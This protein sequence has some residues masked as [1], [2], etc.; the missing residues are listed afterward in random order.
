MEIMIAVSAPNKPEREV[1]LSSDVVVGRG[2]TANLRIISN[3]VSREHC[4]LIVADDKIAIRDLGSS[5]GT[6]LDGTTIEAK[7]DVLLASGSRLEIG[8]L[9]LVVRF[10]EAAL[11][12]EFRDALH[13]QNATLDALEELI[14]ETEHL[15]GPIFDG[16]EEADD[17]E[18]TEPLAL[19]IDP[20][21]LTDTVAILPPASIAPDTDLMGVEAATDDVQFD[22][23]T[24][25]PTVV[26]QASEAAAEEPAPKMKGLFGL[27][28]KDKTKAAAA[29]QNA[30]Q[31]DVSPAAPVEDSA[32]ELV[33]LEPGDEDLAEVGADEL[34]PLDPDDDPNNDSETDEPTVAAAATGM[35]VETPVADEPDV[36]EPQVDGPADD[37]F[38]ADS[39][40]EW[41][42][43]Y[44]E[45]SD[46]GDDE[47]VDP[48]FANFLN[49]IDD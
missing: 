19:T 49:D 40:E 5:N 10:D 14:Q 16:L 13:K 3:E 32:D 22:N 28:R 37:L 48:G 11:P 17:T 42:D 26:D 12:Q 44:L 18:I 20:D 1:K 8:P 27:F 9:K 35:P 21:E 4:R 47:D 38:P 39:D 6:Q 34:E 2:K 24:T 43:E 36:A 30:D 31:A 15:D 29:Q 25:E 7:T 41:A 33:P 46:D 23:S 45:E